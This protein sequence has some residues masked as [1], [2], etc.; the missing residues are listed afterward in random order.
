[1]L[2]FLEASR[3]YAFLF[4]ILIGI[5]MFGSTPIILAFIQDKAK[6]RPAFMNS[7][8][9]TISFGLGALGVFIIGG[10]SDIF[11]MEISF[12]VSAYLS[13]GAIPFV[14]MLKE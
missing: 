10:I 3:T 4:L 5:F 9:M 8:Y 2:I 7:I 11:D 12:R 13:L 1:M 6:E 14:F